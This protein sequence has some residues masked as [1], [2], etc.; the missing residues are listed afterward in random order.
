MGVGLQASG[1]EGDRLEDSRLLAPKRPLGFFK[2]CV[3]SLQLYGKKDL[4]HLLRVVAYDAGQNW[5]A[6]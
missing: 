2:V 4:P 6:F 1:L 3:A 5:P